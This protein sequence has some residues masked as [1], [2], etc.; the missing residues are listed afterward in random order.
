M[1][2]TSKDRGQF[3]KG[4]QKYKKKGKSFTKLKSTMMTERFRSRR[5]DREKGT[6]WLEK[7]ELKKGKVGGKGNKKAEIVQKKQSRRR[8]LMKP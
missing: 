4:R 3:Q 1:E 8:K 2:L 6:P 5:V 7:K